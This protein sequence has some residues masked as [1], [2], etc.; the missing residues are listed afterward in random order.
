MMEE[1]D[2]A[3]TGG[4]LRVVSWPGD[5]PVVLAVHGITANA[6]SWT[7]VARE[8]RGR[9]RLIA[10]DLR[11]RAGS[12]HLP[13]PFGMAA[14]I[15]DLIAVSEYFGVERPALVGHSMG[16]FVV[17]VTAA[18]HDVGPVLMVDGGIALPVPPGI[19]IDT[20][21]HA[22]IG[23]AMR[24]LSMTFDDETAYLDYFRQNPALG[25]HWTPDLAAYI[26]RD[27]TG[28]GSSCNID[29]I[30]ADA[31]DMLTN[32]IPAPHP[33][34]WAPRGLMDEPRGLY[35][36]DQLTGVDAELIPDVNHY[37]ILQGAGARRV[38]DRI[39]SLTA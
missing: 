7:S 30:R 3:V 20:A 36:H 32:P 14:H 19:D 8:L 23:P 29:A 1:I 21:L 16:A 35:Q 2:I 25:D 9:V 17:A 13:G 26:R 5:G 33:L 10:P 34:L 37:T 39:I 11:G 18:A 6:L 4:K 28:T 12:A 15:T 31:H 27:F 24:R 38:A 22:V